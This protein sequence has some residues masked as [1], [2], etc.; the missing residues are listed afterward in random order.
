MMATSGAQG[1][2]GSSRL[3][4]FQGRRRGARLPLPPSWQRG[5]HDNVRM[6]LLHCSCGQQGICAPHFTYS[7][8]QPPL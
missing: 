4:Q 1:P 3:R 7:K 2:Q 6:P 8:G 5:P